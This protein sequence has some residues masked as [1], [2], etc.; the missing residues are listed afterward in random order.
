MNQSQ[1]ALKKLVDDVSILAV[2]RCLI[3][4]L[5]DLLSPDVVY[6]LTDVEV[7]RIAGES[8]E[9][10]AER[11]RTTHKLQV[12]E[13]GM[14]ELQRLK[15]HSPSLLE[16][17]VC[18]LVTAGKSFELI[19][20]RNP[21]IDAEILLRLTRRLYQKNLPACRKRRLSQRQG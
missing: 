13:S 5:P 10:A 6:V 2:E 20:Y 3:Q 12:L 16:I 9:S 19:H 8:S 4:K 1:V 18:I 7:Q 21:Y 15:Q 14:A 17:Q 11:V